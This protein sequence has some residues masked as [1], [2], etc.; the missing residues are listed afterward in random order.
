MARMRWGFYESMPVDLSRELDESKVWGRPKRS[1][2][3]TAAEENEPA[4]NRWDDET[5]SCWACMNLDVSTLGRRGVQSMWPRLLYTIVLEEDAN[6]RTDYGVH[7]NNNKD[8]D[9][10]G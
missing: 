1:E 8:S 7:D 2:P 5:S 4:V 10:N 6:N 3:E 9:N